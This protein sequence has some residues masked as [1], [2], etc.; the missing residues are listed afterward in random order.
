MKKII[1]ITFAL[2]LI[3]CSNNDSQTD[4]NSQSSILLKKMIQTNSLGTITSDIS[5]SGNK[6]INEV[7]TN[8]YEDKYYYTGDLITKFERYQNNILKF[9]CIYNYN[10]NGKVISCNINDVG[11]YTG[12]LS[13]T[14]NSN[15]GITYNTV[16]TYTQ[17]SIVEN[18]TYTAT[19]ANNEI[20]TFTENGSNIAYSYT[21]DSKTNSR[22][23]VLGYD[24][25]YLT[26][27]ESIVGCYQNV[28]QVKKNNVLTSSS[29]YTYNSGEYPLTQTINS[30]SSSGSIQNTKILNYYY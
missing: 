16:F 17:S 28:I 7:Q 26:N 1:N 3:S 22:K 11:Y 4:N 24:K 2:F 20:D 29:I 14:Y 5:Y 30:Y 25:I 10:N 18:K 13:I 15:I 8:G 27:I 9:S 21:Y 23:N 6:I 19:I 12:T